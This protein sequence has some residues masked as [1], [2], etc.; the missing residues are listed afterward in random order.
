MQLFQRNGTRCLPIEQW[1][2]PMEQ[3]IHQ[4][5]GA[6]LEPLLGVR[7]LGHEIETADGR[8]DSLGIDQFGGPVII[9]FKRGRKDNIIN[10][11]L[12]YQLWLDHHRERYES[13]LRK[14]SNQTVDWTAL[15]IICIASA[16]SSYDKQSI[17]L[18]RANIDLV[19][20]AL[21]GQDL[22]GL[23]HVASHR[24]P[25]YAK[26][27]RHKPS[28]PKTSFE[29]LAS[30]APVETQQRLR[31]LVE[32]LH[33]A[34]PDLSINAR[35]DRLE[36]IQGDCVAHLRF[37][38]TSILRLKAMVMVTPEELRSELESCWWPGL[39]TYRRKGDGFEMSLFDEQSIGAFMAIMEASLS[40]KER[41]GSFY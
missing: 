6:N 17:S 25:G 40:L 11:A 4:L 20:Y 28:A 31:Q 5:I 10:Q 29:Q 18:F 19:E 16:F 37:Q 30:K 26:L 1:L 36:M 9:E 2:A 3:D 38:G 24:L 33:E 14:I 7:L 32:R 34:H 8:M 22:L 35:E 41:A 15:R 13:L 27:Q 23:N 39:D 12:S 21:F